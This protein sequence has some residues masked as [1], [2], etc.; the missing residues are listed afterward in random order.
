[1]LS[2]W[3][4]YVDADDYIQLNTSECLY[5]YSKIYDLDML[6]FEASDFQDTTNEPISNTYH[7]LTWLPEKFPPVFS[8][9]NFQEI[10]HRVAVT[11]CLTFYRHDFLK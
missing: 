8:W 9:K 11:A 5:L 3:C 4:Q 6:F 10:I 1:M 7:H 2:I